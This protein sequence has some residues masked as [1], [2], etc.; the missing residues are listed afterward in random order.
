MKAIAQDRYGSADENRKDRVV[1]KELIESGTVTPVI[2]RSYDLSEAPEAIRYVEKGH[3]RGK[4]VIT[5]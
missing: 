5:V 3:T 4:V 1:L 2:D